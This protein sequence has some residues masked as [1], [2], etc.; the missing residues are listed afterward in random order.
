MHP[1]SGPQQLQI[2][3]QPPRPNLRTLAAPGYWP[4]FPVDRCLRRLV[5]S[6]VICLRIISLHGNDVGLTPL[7]ERF[8]RGARV[9]NHWCF[10]LRLYSAPVV[11][12]N[13]PCV[14][15]LATVFQ[16]K[17]SL[18]KFRPQ[19]INIYSRPNPPIFSTCFQHFCPNSIQTCSALRLQIHFG[20]RSP[21]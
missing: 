14:A 7:E 3:Y 2:L 13:T 16:A 4:I 19:F 9:P 1:L 20:T 6:G 11:D 15:L 5:W 12:A 18:G 21:I 8:F 17:P 10:S